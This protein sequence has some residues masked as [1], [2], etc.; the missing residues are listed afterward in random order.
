[1][2]VI[3]FPQSRVGPAALVELLYRCRALDEP[4]L[5]LPGQSC[6]MGSRG[7]GVSAD[8]Q[9]QFRLRIERALPKRISRQQFLAHPIL[10]D[11]RIL[12]IPR[13]RTLP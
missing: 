10:K 4:H 5:D 8:P 13:G 6:A 9:L 1:M 11:L 12:T 7:R 3:E 2:C